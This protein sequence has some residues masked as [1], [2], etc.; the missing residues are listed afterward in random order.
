MKITWFGGTTFRLH[1]GGHVV[2]VDAERAPARVEPSELRGGADLVVGLGQGRETD[3]S[4]WRPRAAERLLDAGAGP[5]VPQIWS[6]DGTSLLIDA[7]DERPL[8]IVGEGAS[9]GGRWLGQAIVV[10]AGSGLAGR[11]AALLDAEPPHLIALAGEDAELDAAFAALRDRL[12]GTGLVA[13]EPGMA[14]EV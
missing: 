9:E 10:L 1:I 12:D 11:G 4:G 7:D 14:V 6:A 5:R 2:V 8:L 3:V 13:L